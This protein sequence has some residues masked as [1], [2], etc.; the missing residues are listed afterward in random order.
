MSY[1]R[2]QLYAMGEPLGDS[3][4]YRKAD[5]GLVLG[6]G[7]GG[8][9]SS[10]GTNTNISELP[11]WARGY[12]KGALERA[13]A[14]SRKGFQ[15]YDDPR[16]AGFSPM[17][18]QAQEGAANMQTSGLTG[19]GGQIAGAA[20]LGGLGQDYQAGQF[21]GGRFGNRQAAQYMSPFIQEA[22]AP[23]LRE[24]QRSSDIL[25]QQNAARAVGQ[26]AFGGSRSA[27]VE[28]ERQRNLGMQMGDIRAKGL[29][30]AYSQAQAQY[31][32]DQARSIQAQQLGEQS[33]QF[34]ANLGLQGL[35]TALQGAGQ[36][37]ALGQQQFQQ[38]MDINKL[39]AGYGAQQQALRQQ[40]LS[41]QYQDFLDEQNYPY[42]QLGFFSDMIRGLPVGQQSTQQ[43]YQAPGSMLGQ[44]AGLGVG[45]LGLSSLYNTAQKAGSG[46]AEGGEVHTYAGD[47]GS[48]TSSDFIQDKLDSIRGDTEALFRAKQ[49]A[50]ARRDYETASY[51]DQLLA[52][53]EEMRAQNA[54][55]NGGLGYAFDQLPAESQDNIIRA[56][57]GGVVAFAA[58]GDEG[59]RKPMSY[60]EQMSAL[61]SFLADIPKHIVS[62]PGYGFNRPSAPE[63][64]TQ[65]AAVA[66]K[67]DRATATRRE[68]YMSAA[69]ED[70]GT[71]ES[72]P[73]TAAS[74][75]AQARGVAEAMGQGDAFEENYNKFLDK[76]TNSSKDQLK[77]IKD[78]LAANAKESED[79]KKAGLGKALAAF[80]FNMAAQASKPGQARRK[81]LAG[82]MESA[83][84]ASPTL[85][86]S[87]AETDRLARAAKDNAMKM[88]LE[89]AKYEVALKKGDQQT[90]AT[91][92]N[93]LEQRK[94]QQA[95][96]G[97]MIRSNKAKEGI[98]ASR[99]GATGNRMDLEVFK[100]TGRAQGEAT[101]HALNIFD[102]VYGGRVP[103][104][105][106]GMSQQQFLQMLERQ[107]LPKF[108]PGSFS[109]SKSQDDEKID[110]DLFS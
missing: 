89:M 35:N 76:L 41:Q 25:G 84:A 55:I 59:E 1:S 100:A 62:Y 68:D 22:L 70:R 27:L 93:N 109:E 37:G 51:V 74:P 42:K 9:G 82:L 97:E 43:I 19:M 6:G 67:F 24:A 60:G 88:N 8:G 79:I 101:K 17:Q 77:S 83:A 69:S 95:Q 32:A 44:V 71:R 21:Q 18:L 107:A 12:A 52:S 78:A 65:P 73:A 110:V 103:K 29:Q 56:A 64:K 33:R 87:A 47:R 7:G 48:V 54:S 45:A 30:D 40:G 63:T 53:N 34:G 3:A 72:K 23:Q 15:K 16:I 20:A 102:K 31:N 80:G 4:T 2:Q 14:L 66:D 81:G 61:G 28:A 96:L 26:G 98:L 50:L 36:L 85:Y 46:F 49:A 75:V 104:E 57:E 92:A 39:Q 94:L 106:K 58:G 90:A 99:A 38:G 13:D 86:E 5:G 91:L 105:A 10:G 11:E 108:L